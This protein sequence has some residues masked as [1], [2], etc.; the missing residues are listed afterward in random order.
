MLK[1]PK[2]LQRN[3]QGM[4]KS[5]HSPCH[6]MFDDCCRW[7]KIETNDRVQRGKTRIKFAEPKF[8]GRCFIP[9]T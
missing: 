9:L 6:N 5:C 7:Y 4:K 1:E 8:V 2:Q 3:P